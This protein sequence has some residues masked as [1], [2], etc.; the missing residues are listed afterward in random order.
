MAAGLSIDSA[1]AGSELCWVEKTGA[2]GLKDVSERV[3]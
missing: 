1:R 3:Q 2:R